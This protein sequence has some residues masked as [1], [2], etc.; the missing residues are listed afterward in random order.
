MS[1][2]TSLALA[3][4]ALPLAAAVLAWLS[5]ANATTKKLAHLPLIL[6]CAAAAV[7]AVILLGQM[8]DGHESRYTSEPLTWFAAGQLDVHF[9]ITVDALATVML[10]MITFIATFIALF[11]SGYMHGDRGYARFFA[12][13]S[14]FVFSMCGLVLANNFLL[15]VAFWEGVGLCSYLLVGYYFEKPSA[16]A[17]AR[18]AFL[19]TRLGDT[20]FLLGIFLLWKMGGGHTDLDL[21]FA[22]IR[23]HPPDPGLLTTAC[24]LL[25]CGAVGKSAQFPLYVWLPD[26]MEG[27]T[28]V[29]ALIHAAT[30]VTAG[31]YLLARC[32]PLFVLCPEAQIVVA[33]VGGITALLAAFLALG[34]TDLKRILAY[35][36]V[37]QLGYMFMALGTGG[38]IS[39]AFAVG[40]AMFHL[41][42]HA[43]FKALL[44]LSAGSVMHAM[45]NVIDITRFSGLRKVLP[46]THLTFLCG[47][48]A[49]A[50]VPLLSGFWS[51]DLILE[52]LTE[53]SESASPYSAG[54][55]VLFLNA[56]LTAGL[57]AFYTFRAYFLT[58]WGPEKIPAEAGDHAHESPRSMTIPLMVLA[59]GAVFVG[60]VVQPFTHW[61]SDFLGT[62]PSLTET[63]API[64]RAVEHHLNWTLISISASLAIA[65]IVLAYVLYRDG[66][67]KPLGGIDTL[68]A[69]SRN[70]LYVD[71]VYYALIVRPAE[72]LAFLVRVFDGFLDGLTRLVAAMPRLLAALIRPLQNGLV[73]FYALAMALGLTVF[74]A[75][76]IFRMA[77]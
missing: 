61:F 77:R 10:G 76:V 9:T 48:A 68:L 36:T 55:F 65:G 19:V 17:A 13:M 2:P 18:K 73:Q 16:A 38:A 32:A 54:Y 25:F 11:S 56:C 45:G 5:A 51:K 52:S 41:F 29:S 1:E 28:P 75:F 49:L 27:P 69:L 20:G 15:L 46:I 63:Q 53:A 6:A 23:D 22:H 72:V 70:K 26:A 47:A 30:M 44:F 60:G 58:F 34:Q 33:G 62:S 31:V 50:G 35:S 24:L 4:L 71:E 12:V 66:Q 14:F 7:L 42:T 40:A 37:S 74:V 39:P 21:L 43:F 64:A 67:E 57:T 59:V 3:I 8:L